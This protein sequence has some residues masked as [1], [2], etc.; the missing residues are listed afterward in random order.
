MCEGDSPAKNPPR[1]LSRKAI[2][3]ASKKL[4]QKLKRAEEA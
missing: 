4:Q 2:N 3:E 1:K